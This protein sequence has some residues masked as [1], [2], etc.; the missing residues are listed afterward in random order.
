RTAAWAA[1]AVMPGLLVADHALGLVDYY[2]VQNGQRAHW[3]A[4]AEFLRARA[5]E[6]PLRV[7]TINYPTMLYYLRP[8]DW[9]FQVP[10]EFERN[11]VVSIESWMIA[12][13][14]DEAKQKVYEPGAKNHVQWHREM[15]ARDGALLAFVVTLPELMQKDPDHSL[16][17]VLASQFDLVL[18]LPCW[19]GP[20]DESLFV[21]LPKQP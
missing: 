9:R 11:R 20:K 5:G 7:A 17:S 8:G 12:E 21:Y 16:R 18:H 4:A 10:P 1:A 3:R 15:A 6:Q 13:G 2:S 19:V 14:K